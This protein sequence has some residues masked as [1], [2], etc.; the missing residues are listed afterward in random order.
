MQKFLLTFFAVVFVASFATNPAMAGRTI[1]TVYTNLEAELGKPVSMK[2]VESAFKKCSADRGWR[3]NKVAPGKLVGKLAVRGKHYVE[4]SVS[5]N[6]KEYKISYQDSK[7]MKYKA[8]ANTIHKRYNSWVKNLD[9]D[10]K[11]CLR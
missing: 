4:V 1:V 3:F 6:S 11:L 10:V 9:N 2:K 7:N 8:S 5:Y